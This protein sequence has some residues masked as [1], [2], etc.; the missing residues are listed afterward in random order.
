[1]PKTGSESSV[2]CQDGCKEIKQLRRLLC[3]VL[4]CVLVLAKVR[5]CSKLKQR[6]WTD[7]K[8]KSFSE[9]RRLAPAGALY[10]DQQK[11]SGRE[12]LCFGWLHS[13]VH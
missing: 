11:R 1:M 13:D 5:R 9:D 6:S 7:T 3:T 2:T 10:K 12:P 4:D 8:K